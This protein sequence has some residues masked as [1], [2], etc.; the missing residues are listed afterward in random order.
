[1]K[2]IKVTKDYE[3]FKNTDGHYSVKDSSGSYVNAIKKIEILSN[4]GLMGFKNALQRAELLSKDKLFKPNVNKNNS[5]STV[6]LNQSNQ[7]LA[8]ES[9]KSDSITEIQVIPNYVQ[10]S[11]QKIKNFK[12][13]A[14]ELRVRE[15][16]A[17]KLA[18]IH[19]LRQLV[20]I[21]TKDFLKIPNLGQTS[22]VLVEQLLETLG[23][24]LNARR[25]SIV[26]VD[27]S[28]SELKKTQINYPIEFFKLDLRSYR[29]LQRHSITDAKALLLLTKR[30]LLSLT[31]L[32]LT[33]RKNILEAINRHDMEL[34]T[35]RMFHWEEYNK[36]LKSLDS[37]FLPHNFN[38]DQNFNQS[39]RNFIEEYA[40][41][42]KSQRNKFIFL[43]R[44]VL[45]N[46]PLSLE[47]IGKKFGDISRQRVN[48]IEKKIVHELSRMLMHGEL[49]RSQYQIDPGFL[50][51]WGKA[52]NSLAGIDEVSILDFQESV[53]YAWD[54][55]TTDLE[56]IFHFVVTVFSG[57][58]KSNIAVQYASRN[59]PLINA[60]RAKF[61]FTK[62]LKI[63]H[64]RL[65]EKARNHLAKKEIYT[66]NDLPDFL[67]S[68]HKISKGMQSI[69]DDLMLVPL[70]MNG[71]VMWLDFFGIK[72]FKTIERRP[73]DTRQIFLSELYNLMFDALSVMNVPK[74]SQ[75]IFA[76]RTIKH[77]LNRPTFEKLSE[78]L[79]GNPVQPVISRD[80]SVFLE[81]LHNIFVGEDYSQAY[82]SLSEGLIAGFE[83]S[84]EI[85][86][87]A[88][89]DFEKFIYLVKL[90]FGIKDIDLDSVSTLWAILDGYTPQRYF[91]LTSDEIRK[92]R[93]KVQSKALPA[94]IKLSGFRNI[95]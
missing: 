50:K 48:Q 41:S 35:G 82:F 55:A 80:Q 76:L 81:K 27:D 87:L 7:A 95:Y 88:N 79:E 45:T 8:L 28:G 66:L 60:F 57:K 14:L 24:A 25:N 53:C 11:K 86:Q 9:K 17:L 67:E 13:E 85:H 74:R 39:I 4:H 33:S 78:K 37:E 19:N 92:R 3:I 22:L 36:E 18:G 62:D 29:C 71:S 47:E 61:K 73:L 68:Q 72:G 58:V 16:N 93:N 91:H 31:G 63:S 69:I 83:E 38:K 75:D 77:P 46:T 21:Q 94:T 15:Y 65:G 70:D 84:K 42:I 54:I 26:W 49:S 43:N 2:S 5:L 52:V 23:L 64:F 90:R 40:D 56:D 10:D 1:M 20:S 30:S 59:Q 32:G 51:L 34:G 44:I 12:L 6:S 89:N